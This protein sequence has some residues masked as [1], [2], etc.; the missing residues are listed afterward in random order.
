MEQRFNIMEA[1][2]SDINTLC[3]AI[4]ERAVNDYVESIIKSRNHVA[5]GNGKIGNIQED[6]EDFFYSDYFELL[7]SGVG[8]FDNLDVDTIINTCKRKGKYGI[9]KKDHKCSSCKRKNCIHKK[10][11]AFYEKMICPKEEENYANI[12]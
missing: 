5:L 12:I 8:N 6:I 10:R 9:W 2:V 3:M 7:L 1:D 11:Y 4:I